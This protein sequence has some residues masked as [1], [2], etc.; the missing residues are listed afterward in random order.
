MGRAGCARPARTWAGDPGDGG[1]AGPERGLLGGGRGRGSRTLPGAEGGVGVARP[2]TCWRSE[3]ALGDPPLKSR[4]PGKD[5]G[6]K[7][8]PSELATAPRGLGAEEQVVGSSRPGACR[9]GGLPADPSEEPERGCAWAVGW[10]RS[11][12]PSPS[13]G[14]PGNRLSPS[15]FHPQPGVGGSAGLGVGGA[16]DARQV[17]RAEASGPE[18]V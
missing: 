1:A 17:E 9:S 8:A 3:G 15:R 2:F 12:T 10:A 6:A 14:R 16:R 7:E 18:R 5:A 13:F 4:P 11:S